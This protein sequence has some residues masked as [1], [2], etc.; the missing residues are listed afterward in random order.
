MKNDLLAL[1][2][3]IAVFAMCIWLNNHKEHSVAVW[4]DAV[5]GEG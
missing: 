1:T 5:V 2:L 4:V 3:V